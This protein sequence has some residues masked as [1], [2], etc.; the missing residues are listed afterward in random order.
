METWESHYKTANRLIQQNNTLKAIY[1][2][3]QAFA[4]NPNYLDL[5][6]NLA[7]SYV[8]VKQFAKA[9]PL[10]KL[11]AKRNPEHA[12]I[13]AQLAEVYLELGK[14]EDAIKYFEKAIQLSPQ[15]SEWHHNLAVLYLREQCKEK[16]LQHFKIT[17][18][19]QPNNDTARHMVNALTG[20][21]IENAPTDYVIDLFNQYS[22]F[23]D[24]HVQEK[25]NY[26]APKLLRQVISQY[27]PTYTK[28]KQILDL[29]CGTGL[30]SIYFR[31]LAQTLVGV[32]ITMKMLL[33]AKELN[34]YDALCCCNILD[35]LPGEQDNFF[36]III[37]ADVLVYC[38]DLS[39]IFAL[40]RNALSDVGLFAFTVERFT[41]NA[42]ELQATGRFAHSHEYIAGLANQHGFK[43]ID[44]KEIV[45]R[46]NNSVPIEGGLYLLSLT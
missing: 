31:D 4:L 28:Q 41:G 39:K 32:D 7:M 24:K 5:Q 43:M 38:G 37:A 23:Y 42:F 12:E 15:R 19:Y 25:L 20:N 18:E 40:C 13:Q 14:Y 45:L 29:G 33:K 35:M 46:E 44:Y 11:T 36:D 34:A 17:L 9:L 22:Q 2:Y 3:E 8:M 26:Q 27:L 16:A 1:H 21:T 6:Q 30:C 10:L